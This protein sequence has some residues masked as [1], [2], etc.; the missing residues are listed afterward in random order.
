MST[1][2]FDN[3]AT[4]EA[5]MTT[6]TELLSKQLSDFSL[7]PAQVIQKIVADGRDPGPMMGVFEQWEARIASDQFGHALATFQGVCPQIKKNRQIDLGGGKG[8]MFASLDDIMREIQ[9]HLTACGIAVTFSAGMT[10]GGQMRA[11]CTVRHGRHSEQSEVTLPVPSQMRVNDTQKMGAALSYA[12]R[13]ALCAALNIIVTDEDVDAAGMVETI[14]EEQIDTLNQWIQ[15][16][17]TDIDRFLKWLEI[18][19]LANMSVKQ[20]PQALAE[21]K[22]KASK[23]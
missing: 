22:R 17:N 1:G 12:K 7:T 15:T 3:H 4:Q 8:P 13:Y 19:K 9:P 2:L 6:G 18:D 21:L 16:T 5:K 14:S 23:K 10:D 11:V 20:F